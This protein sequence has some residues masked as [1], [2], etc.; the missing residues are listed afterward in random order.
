MKNNKYCTLISRL[1]DTT[2]EGRV[3]WQKTSR[4]NEYTTDV[5]SYSVTI[6][7]L[8]QST[9]TIAKDANDKYALTLINEDG[10]TIDIQE[11]VPAD[12]DYKQ[13]TTLFAEAR[14][15]FYKVDDV[16]DSIIEELK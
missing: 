13:M 8:S 11:I 7:S 1:I 5:S 10:D 6:T 14:R 4:Q 9:F 12:D 16:L 3:Y 15:S 2:I